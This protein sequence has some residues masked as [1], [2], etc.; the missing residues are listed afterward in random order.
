MK[1]ALPAL[2]FYCC[3]V[4]WSCSGSLERDEYIQWIEDYNNGLH[5]RKTVNE[6]GFDL[7]YH[8]PAY[9]TLMNPS[10]SDDGN[11]QGFQQY[12]LRIA[13][14]D[15]STDIVTY[16]AQ[17]LSDKQ[18]RQYY[19]SY[20]FQN[21]VYLEQDGKQI[22]CV[23]FHAEQSDLNKSRAFI[24]GFESAPGKENDASVLVINSPLFGS[25]PVKIKILKQNIPSL[26]L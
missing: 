21:D 7:Q 10:Q 25:L 19:F 18:Q 5:V 11:Q 26:K 16:S 6:F 23:L 20:L 12:V 9:V 15:Q 3:A 8:P 22:P 14:A 24:L 13:L 1:K 2:A 4:L 17:S